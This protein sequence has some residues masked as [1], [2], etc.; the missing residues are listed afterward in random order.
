M[1]TSWNAFLCLASNS[2]DEDI[3]MM[4]FDLMNVCYLASQVLFIL[5]KRGKFRVNVGKVIKVEKYFYE[6]KKTF[7]KSAQR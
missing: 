3:C 2:Y 1:D 7:G 6:N 5:C 4:H